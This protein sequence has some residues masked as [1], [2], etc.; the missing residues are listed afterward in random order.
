MTSNENKEGIVDQELISYKVV[1]LGDIAVGK[2]S[3]VRR[4][5][6]FINMLLN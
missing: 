5:E 1:F 2:S 3:I 6:C 4:Y